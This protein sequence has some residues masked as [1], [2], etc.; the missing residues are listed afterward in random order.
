MSVKNSLGRVQGRLEQ[1]KERIGEP[2]DRATE[3]AQNEGQ[4]ENELKNH[5][6]RLRDLWDPPLSPAYTQWESQKKRERDQETTWRNN[7]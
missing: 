1:A 3:M 6:Q 2:E 5:E 7:Y 4:K